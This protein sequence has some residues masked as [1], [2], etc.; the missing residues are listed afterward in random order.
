MSQSKRQRFT[1]PAAFAS[2][3]TTM[4]A[5][6]SSMSRVARKKKGVKWTKAQRESFNQKLL[7]K[8]ARNVDLSSHYYDLES[9]NTAVTGDGQ[10]H[11]LNPGTAIVRGDTVNE[12]QGDSIHMKN[13]N[14]RYVISANQGQSDDTVWKVYLIQHF[15]PDAGGTAAV[16]D[17]FEAKDGVNAVSPILQPRLWESMR[18]FKILASATHV[19]KPTTWGNNGGTYL[20]TAS[21]NARDYGEFSVRLNAQAKYNA[22][23]ATEDNAIYLVI[24]NSTDTAVGG[25][26]GG[27]FRFRSRLTFAP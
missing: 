9:G 6:S 19:V 14:V 2:Q 4:T 20:T 8:L 21:G 17:I 18:D 7:Y 24:K 16:T 11:N 12:R 15:H 10:L 25:V 13:I 5:G 23:G 27:T 26:A 3:G 22:A 1:P